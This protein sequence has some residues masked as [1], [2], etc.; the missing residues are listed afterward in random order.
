MPLLVPIMRQ[1]TLAIVITLASLTWLAACNGPRVIHEQPVL[2]TGDRVPNA[3]SLIA[4]A[5]A[6]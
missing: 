5:R 4:V 2:V 1:R 3:D 6:T